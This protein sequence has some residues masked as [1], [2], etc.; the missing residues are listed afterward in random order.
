MTVY[1]VKLNN[2]MGHLVIAG[3]YTKLPEH[4]QN[5]VYSK[6]MLYVES[7]YDNPCMFYR[8]KDPKLSKYW[9]YHCGNDTVNIDYSY[10]V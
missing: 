7:Y 8:M 10:A 2:D 1:E 9:T 4:I 6:M 5:F 3:D